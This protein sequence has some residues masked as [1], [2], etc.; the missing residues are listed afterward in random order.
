MF[1]KK[2]STALKYSRIHKD[3]AGLPIS[4]SDENF[5]GDSDKS[6]EDALRDAILNAEEASRFKS[7]FLANMSHEI[8][9]PMNGIIGLAELALAGGGLSEKTA[10]YL[11]KIK[12]SATG[13]LAIIN[14]IL[15][16]SKIEAGKAELESIVFNFKDVFKNCETVAKL[17]DKSDNVRIV[18]DCVPLAE[19]T[20]KGDPTKLNQILMNLLSN[21]IKFTNDGVV[22]LRAEIVEKNADKLTASFIVKDTGIGMDA[23][24]I[25]KAF[26]PF[27][28]VDASITRKYGGTGLGLSITKS[29]LEMMGGNLIV[30]SKKGKGSSFGF[31]LDFLVVQKES[32][33]ANYGQPESGKNAEGTDKKPI[34]HAQALVCEDNAI[35][36]QVIEEHLLRIN[37]IPV[38]AENGKIGVNMAKMRMRTGKPFD[39]I[40]M[41]IHMPVMDGLEAMQK[42]I[43][44]GNKSPVIAMTA[45]VMR[46]DRELFI[47]SGM[48]DYISK[49]FSSKDLWDCLIKYLEPVRFED[50]NPDGTVYENSEIINGA[51]GL[52]KTA[53]DPVLYRKIKTDF[54]FENINIAEKLE[55]AAVS[56]DM[57]TAYRLAHT[58][59]G[60]STLIGASSLSEAVLTLEKAYADGEKDENALNLVKK[61]LAD[62]LEVLKPEAEK[63]RE[64]EE[65]VSA[66]AT[67]V[68]SALEIIRRLEPLLA[69][70]SSEAIDFIGEIKTALSKDMSREL[71]LY[72]SDYE[73]DAALKELHI[74]KD[75]LGGQA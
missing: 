47:K 64:E 55:N 75:K 12:E 10:D 13:L 3:R 56:G 33:A 19:E 23:E 30:E 2:K 20:V 1:F 57:K 24:Q 66:M 44:A 15:D 53:G 42:L 9:T 46:E 25:Q 39:I 58:L 16:I 36:R 60:V 51:S 73:F 35:N 71:L 52:E 50:I 62:V 37:I 8:R 5:C 40:L 48:S 54:Y 70:G 49:P 45:N 22:E 14:D 32:P 31:T 18:F 38:I 63:C 67:D 26:E 21:A 61:R 41:D 68:S 17:S 72:L 65:G 29:L 59:K 28:Q 6:R 27:S 74:I 43:E 11:N 34:F 7:M 69:E 4:R